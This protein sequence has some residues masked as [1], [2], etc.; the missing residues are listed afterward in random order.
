M[1]FLP[2]E[3][4]SLA[5]CVMIIV[6]F[7]LLLQFDYDNGFGDRVG[8]FNIDLYLS[9]GD[10]DCGTWVTTICDKPGKGC[11]D[12]REWKTLSVDLSAMRARRG[13]SVVSF[14]H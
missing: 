4:L 2:R 12:T 13:S 9:G 1:T 11:H 14:L 3:T 5:V 6:V 10:G 7:S 8:R